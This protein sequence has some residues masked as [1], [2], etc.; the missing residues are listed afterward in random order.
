VNPSKEPDWLGKSSVQVFKARSPAMIQFSPP[1]LYA[2]SIALL[3]E[4]Q[5]AYERQAGRRIPVIAYLPPW[6]G[7]GPNGHP[8]ERHPARIELQYFAPT[9]VPP[10]FRRWFLNSPFAILI[11]EAVW[12]V[13]PHLLDLEGSKIVLRASWD[14]PIWK[15]P[16]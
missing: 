5:A 8:P 10:A 3:R 11:P 16:E 6:V 4:L 12:R 14:G 2:V 13:G 7:Y 1:N 9:A 15:L